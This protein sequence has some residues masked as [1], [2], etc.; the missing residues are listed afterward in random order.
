MGSILVLE[1]SIL[2]HMVE[3]NMVLVEG[4]ILVLEGSMGCDRSSSL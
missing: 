2:A 1:D 3:D 4:S